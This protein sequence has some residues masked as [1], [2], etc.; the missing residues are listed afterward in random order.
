MKVKFQFDERSLA[1]LED[2]TEDEQAL[3]VKIYPKGKIMFDISKEED[4][5][6]ERLRKMIYYINHT[7]V[8]IGTKLVKLL[9]DINCPY[10]KDKEQLLDILW[11]ARY[12]KKT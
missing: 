1:V 4:S 7:G 10:T 12:G 5:L 8:P 11:N 3:L 2:F 6:D 9:Q